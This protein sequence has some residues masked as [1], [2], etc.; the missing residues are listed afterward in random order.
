MTPIIPWRAWALAMLTLAALAA[1]ATATSIDQQA[2][3]AVAAGYVL[4]ETTAN[5][6]AALHEAGAIPDSRRAAVKERLQVALASLGVAQRAL[7]AQQ[8]AIA[9]QQAAEAVAPVQAELE[10]LQ[11]VN[12]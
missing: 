9:R 6:A 7:Q 3:E 5:T 4:V 10:Q 2:R 1:C 12:R 8:W 11:E